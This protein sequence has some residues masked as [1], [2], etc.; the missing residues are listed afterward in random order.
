MSVYFVFN[1]AG[2]EHEFQSWEGETG[3]YLARKTQ[4]VEGG[5]ILSAPRRTGHLESQISSTY[6]YTTGGDLESQCGVNPGG[7]TAGYALIQHE[8]GR[9]HIIMPRTARVLRFVTHG[10][11]VYARRVS[12][13]GNPALHY[14]TR[15]LKEMF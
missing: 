2:M 9:P 6:G 5:A 11:V 7:S 14:L 13:P 3:R 4:E 8:G 10:M 12:H 15:W 1:E